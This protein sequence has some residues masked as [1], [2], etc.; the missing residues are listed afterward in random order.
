LILDNI[1]SLFMSSSIE[2]K[3]SIVAMLNRFVQN[4]VSILMPINIILLSISVA[5]WSFLCYI[6][7]DVQSHS[8]I[9]PLFLYILK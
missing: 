2:V 9:P 3:C 1:H 8:G 7:L 6:Y 5:K 4:L